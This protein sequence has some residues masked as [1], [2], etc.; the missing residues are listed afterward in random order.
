MMALQ[1]QQLFLKHRQH[2]LTEVLPD[3]FVISEC[4]SQ[5]MLQSVNVL[6]TKCF[7]L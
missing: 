3:T 6:N 2:N 1:K 4:F 5:L 7:H